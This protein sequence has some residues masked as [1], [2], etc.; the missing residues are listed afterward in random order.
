MPSRRAPRRLL[1][2]AEVPMVSAE[3]MRNVSSSAPLKSMIRGGGGRGVSEGLEVAEGRDNGGDG[4]R[5]R[6]VAGRD[7]GGESR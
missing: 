1:A 7:I 5:G 4:D 3:G 6:T 2:E